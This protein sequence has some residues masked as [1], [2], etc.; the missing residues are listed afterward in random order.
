MT[1]EFFPLHLDVASCF[2]VVPGKWSSREEK[3]NVTDLSLVASLSPSFSALLKPIT[4]ISLS[5]FSCDTSRFPRFSG[6]LTAMKIIGLISFPTINA[7]RMARM[8]GRAARFGLEFFSLLHKT[9][10]SFV[11]E[12]E[13]RYESRS[14]EPEENFRFL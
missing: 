10:T 2:A 9:T 6:I 7:G 3:G 5:H 8:D 13:S 11:Y 4:A 12:Q 14:V 1:R